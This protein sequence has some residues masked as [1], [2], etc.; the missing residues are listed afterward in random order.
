MNTLYVRLKC[1]V[2]KKAKNRTTHTR[3]LID[4]LPLMVTVF[5]CFQRHRCATR[6]GQ[7][8]FNQPT[9]SNY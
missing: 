1:L 7:K 4:Q 3:R 9:E 2:K 6:L 8:K 5:L